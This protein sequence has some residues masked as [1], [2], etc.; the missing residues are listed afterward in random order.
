M[1]KKI[2]KI[3]LIVQAGRLRSL[4]PDSKVSRIGEESLVWR[5]AI[6]PTPLGN[7]YKVLLRYRRNKGV[8][9]Y[10]LEPR[11]LLARGQKALPHVYSTPRQKLCL[12]F[13]DGREWHAGMLLTETI[14]PWASEWLLHYEIWLATGIWKGGGTSHAEDGSVTESL[15]AEAARRNRRMCR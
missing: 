5:H 12:F 6:I 1:G 2:N 9:C 10:V 14:V 7:S 13:P 11:L 4:F 15:K 8:D 3:S